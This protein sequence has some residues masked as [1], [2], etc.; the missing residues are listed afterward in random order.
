MFGLFGWNHGNSSIQNASIF[1]SV[2]G[3]NFICFGIFGSQSS[4]SLYSEVQNVKT[5]I[6]M[7]VG[8]RYA[9]TI[10]GVQQS[11]NC[12]VYNVSVLNSSVQS[13][14]EVGGIIGQQYATNILIKNL[15]ISQTNISGSNYVGGIIGSSYNSIVSVQNTKL[16]LIRLSASG[17]NKI[18]LGYAEGNTFSFSNASSTTNYIN[19]VQTDCLNI[20][21]EISQT[22]C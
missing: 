8:S 3:T 2:Q 6:I 20:M 16:Q 1:F 15:T 13:S 12:T 22:G 17:E 11:K 5:S 18:V 10:Y 19:N 7:S 9:G 4:N 21:C 14:A